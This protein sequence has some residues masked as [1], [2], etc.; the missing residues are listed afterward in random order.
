MEE[1]RKYKGLDNNKYREMQNRIQREMIQIKETY[2]IEKCKEIEIEMKYD[3]FNLNRKIKEMTG[4]GKKKQRSILK[5]Q[6]GN[7]VIDVSNMGKLYKRTI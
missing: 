1:R 3:A 5:D 7:L 6:N 4:T 2:M